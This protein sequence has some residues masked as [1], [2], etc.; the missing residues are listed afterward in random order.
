MVFLTSSPE[1]PQKSRHPSQVKSHEGRSVAEW[2]VNSMRD[3][4]RPG[5]S[6][7]NGA[8]CR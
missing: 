6:W 2:L 1:K 8:S 7:M 3:D 5:D 4:C